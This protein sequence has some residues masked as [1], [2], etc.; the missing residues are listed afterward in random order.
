MSLKN[1]SKVKKVI[2]LAFLVLGCLI[3]VLALHYLFS[4]SNPMEE[5]EVE[6]INLNKE[7]VF[8]DLENYIIEKEEDIWT[9][10]NK[11]TSLFFTV[12]DSWNL[13]KKSTTT[14]DNNQEKTLVFT[15][16][17]HIED[18]DNIYPE[19]GC[20]IYF[21]VY[22]EKNYYQHL[23]QKIDSTLQG[24]NDTELIDV[25]GFLGVIYDTKNAIITRIPEKEKQRRL[26]F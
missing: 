12:P 21:T 5:K 10:T 25:N 14:I 3:L 7:Y 24:D 16:P 22:K 2:T 9:I 11:N 4:K 6:I 8:E 20:V 18:T 15:S 13:D 19:E 23:S 26:F 17:G 1:I